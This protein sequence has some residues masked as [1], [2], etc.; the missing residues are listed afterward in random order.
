MLSG[1]TFACA[2]WLDLRLTTWFLVSAL[3]LGVLLVLAR[4]FGPMFAVICLTAAW[5]VALITQATSG[6]GIYP[7]VIIGLPFVVAASIATLIQGRA[8]RTVARSAPLMLP[9]TLT[10]LLIP[11]FTA[12]LWRAVAS[13]APYHFGLAAMLTVVPVLA[14]LRHRIRSQVPVEIRESLGRIVDSADGWKLAL[15]RLLRDVDEAQREALEAAIKRRVE[16]SFTVR[17]PDPDQ[18]VQKLVGPVRR[19][20]DLRLVTTALGIAVI[21]AAYIYMLAWTLVPIEASTKWV[22]GTVPTV[23]ASFAGASVDLPTGPYLGVATLLGIVATAVLLAFVVTED[24]YEA[25]LSDA[26][27]SDPL[28]EHV[29]VAVPYVALY[30]DSP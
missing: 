30:V 14:L 2:D 13:L 28:D 9:V 10:I 20:L 29:L 18:V 3:I 21:V 12:D 22:E 16:A 24:N 5:G 19:Q 6:D 17:W 15:A 25:E 23:T 1:L 4:L 8:I 26:L 7:W 11:L 27:L